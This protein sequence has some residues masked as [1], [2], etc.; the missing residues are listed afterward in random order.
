MRVI[1]LFVFL[2]IALSLCSLP[3]MA[4]QDDQTKPDKPAVDSTKP[5]EADS[6]S[7]E[8]DAKD[9]NPPQLANI[10]NIKQDKGC[11]DYGSFW[12]TDRFGS[13]LSVPAI[14]QSAAQRPRFCM[15]WI[16]L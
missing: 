16:R 14:K 2:A 3:A 10:P 4:A 5:K 13:D 15:A 6:A 7:Q 1:R 12:L 11:Q 8:K 9:A